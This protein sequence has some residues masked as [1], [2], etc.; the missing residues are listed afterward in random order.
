MNAN[1]SIGRLT[2][3]IAGAMFIL[4]LAVSQASASVPSPTASTTGGSVGPGWVGRRATNACPAPAPGHAMCLAQVVLDPDTGQHATT[5]TP[6]GYGPADLQ[7]AYQ[8][9]VGRGEGQTIAVVAA[10]DNPNAESDLRRYRATYGLPRC[11]TANGCF[12]K[13][14]QRGG[15]RYPPPDPGWAAEISL[16]LDMVSAACP[17]CNI[18]LVEADDNSFVNLTRAVDQAAAS[19]ATAISNSYGTFEDIPDTE[20]LPDGTRIG[21]HY[22][23]P[24]IAITAS[25]GDSGYGL[26]Y[27]ASSRYTIAVG[28]TSLSAAGNARGWK[29][30]AWRYGGSGCSTYNAKPAWQ[31]G[32]RCNKR[33]V[34]DVSAV[35]DPNTGVAVYNT[36][37]VIPGG[38]YIYGG[39]SASSP[40]IAA[41][42]G[43]AGGASSVDYPASLLYAQPDRFHDVTRG[44]NGFCTRRYLC[45][46]GPGY[47]APTGLGTPR[48]AGAFSRR[49]ISDP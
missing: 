33:V 14:N 25:S 10:F 35:A 22:D 41:V 46:A 11:T 16:D 26:S 47:D 39:T 8:L 38:W 24:G 7:S 20:L 2:A 19:G 37:G 15:T 29:E 1:L 18:L 32:I 42:F 43:L 13:I 9:P 12:T 49:S 40:I 27:P 4:P 34:T 44:G 23:H 3:L 31:A 21:D 17:N 45:I 28:G 48:G 6:L 30:S 36:Y 5:T